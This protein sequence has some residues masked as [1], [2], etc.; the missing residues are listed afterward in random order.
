MKLP[1][2]KQIE[3]VNVNNSN[4]ISNKP[5][6]KLLYNSNYKNKYENINNF[7]NKWIYLR[8]KLFRFKLKNFINNFKN[9][10]LNYNYGLKT[11]NIINTLLNNLISY[12][13]INENNSNI[14]GMPGKLLMTHMINFL[15]NCTE[16]E[17]ILDQENVGETI[18]IVNSDMISDIESKLSKEIPE[19]YNQKLEILQIFKD[20]YKLQK[21]E[22]NPI[23]SESK[24]KKLNKKFIQKTVELK[25]NDLNLI[26]S[27]SSRNNSVIDI[28]DITSDSYNISN[29]SLI[30]E[31]EIEDQEDN[32]NIHK[33]NSI[34]SEYSEYS[35]ISEFSEINNSNI[36]NGVNNNNNNQGTDSSICLKSSKSDISLLNG[37]IEEQQQASNK[38]R[39]K[40]SGLLNLTIQLFESSNKNK[41][42]NKSNKNMNMNNSKI[43][44]N[45]NSLQEFEESFQET[46]DE[47][48][49]AT[50]TM[51]SGD[52]I[53]DVIKQDELILIAPVSTSI[54]RDKYS[55][56]DYRDIQEYK[57]F[58]GSK[59]EGMGYLIIDKRRNTKIQNKHQE[60]DKEIKEINDGDKSDDEIRILTYYI[61]TCDKTVIS[62]KYLNAI[63]SLNKLKVV[64][65]SNYISAQN[66][67]IPLTVD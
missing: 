4:I 56:F 60:S 32:E 2:S 13:N 62:D 8:R 59:I 57:E 43:R 29:I 24:K 64:N 12:D 39:H 6:V 49:S 52:I 44:S 53:P 67:K 17:V 15:T 48:T 9:L 65:D 14:N 25:N 19:E 45:G 11:N 21:P 30:S 54:T 3:S 22:L 36:T 50:S 1:K 5:P 10:K 23:I 18:T 63:S 66:I 35:Q 37:L 38:L 27:T 41:N 58:F 55:L 26:N 28:G 33:V 34:H 16:N 20:Y 31:I 61:P 51:I 7:L 47:I 46:N 42:K 40:T